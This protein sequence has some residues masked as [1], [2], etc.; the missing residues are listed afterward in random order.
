MGINKLFI[1]IYIQVK[2]EI[3]EKNFTG[4]E[5]RE[6]SNSFCFEVL[7][8]SWPEPQGKGSGMGARSPLINSTIVEVRP[9]SVP[10][11]TQE[12]ACIPTTS[13]VDALS[14]N[15]CFKAWARSHI[16][17]PALFGF[18]YINSTLT[19]H[20]LWR[21]SHENWNLHWLKFWDADQHIV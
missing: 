7:H 13:F 8:V 9:L 18:I 19:N 4:C 20:H 14:F 17:L 21:L 10:Y 15:F 16:F 12:K 1:K 5:P 11:I 3:I 2:C 6:M